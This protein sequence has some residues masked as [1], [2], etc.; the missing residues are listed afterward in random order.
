M[1]E[2]TTVQGRE[3][4]QDDIELVRRLIEANPSWNRTRLSEE[5]CVLWNW[6]ATNG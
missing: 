1:D 2:T 5:L 4:T 6:R 3:I